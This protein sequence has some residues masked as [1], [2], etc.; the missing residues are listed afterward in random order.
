MQ[1]DKFVV[2]KICE[3]KKIRRRHK[4]KKKKKLQRSTLSSF[5]NDDSEWGSKQP[6]QMQTSWQRKLRVKSSTLM[7]QLVKSNIPWE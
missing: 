6:K 3:L 1:T 5:K 2:Q 4:N 7:A